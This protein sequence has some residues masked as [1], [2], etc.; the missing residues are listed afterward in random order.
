MRKQIV[1][2]VAGPTASGKSALALA[3]AQHHDGVVVNADSMQ[4]YREIPILGAQPDAVDRKT[5]PHVLYGHRSLMYHYSAAEWVTEAIDAIRA[6]LS[7]NQQPILTGGTGMYLR[8]LLEGFS[9]MPTVPDAVRRHVSDLYDM[10]GPDGF[11]HALRDVDP[12]IA[13]RLHPTDRQRMIRAREIFEVSGTPLSAWQEQP[14]E[15]TAPELHYRAITLLPPREQLYARINKRFALMLEHGALAEA[16]Q[17]QMLQPD[18]AMPGTRALGLPSLRDHLDGRLTMDEAIEQSQAQS[19]QYA[20]R[21]YTWFR[22][23][24]LPCPSM[25]LENGKDIDM[26]EKFLTEK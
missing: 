3:L 12:V 2:I 21:Q 13:D 24:P 5:A 7:R 16:Q 10:L 22:N 8:T 26:A 18:P 20:K 14:K 11:H 9:P 6:I 15:N 23:Q 17:V 25:V 4:V 19:R 1:W